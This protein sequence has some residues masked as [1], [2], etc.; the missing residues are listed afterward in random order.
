MGPGAASRENNWLTTRRGIEN[1]IIRTYAKQ[2]FEE[3]NCMS[4]IVLNQMLQRGVIVALLTLAAPVRAEWIWVE[5]EQPSRATVNRHPWYDQVKREELSGGDFI[6]NFNEQKAG[7]AEYTFKVNE[8]GQYDF[9]V[10]ANPVQARLSYRLGE[11]PWTP[12]DLKGQTV[13]NVNIAADGKPDLR[14]LV[15]AKAGSIA[16]VDRP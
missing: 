14:F 9:W 10:R 1:G 12:I 16:A 13:G 11:G 2:D 6:S 3:I 15:W 8:S 4:S 7:E 5:G